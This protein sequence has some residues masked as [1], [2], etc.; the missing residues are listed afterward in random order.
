M[1]VFVSTACCQTSQHSFILEEKKKVTFVKKRKDA[2][3]IKTVSYT[4]TP[5]KRIATQFA[6]LDSV[7]IFFENIED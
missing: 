2:Q 6:S 4:N 5:K 7:F 1:S 3:N